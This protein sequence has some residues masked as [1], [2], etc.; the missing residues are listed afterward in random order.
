LLLNGTARVGGNGGEVLLDARRSI[1][2]LDGMVGID[3]Q[4]LGFRSGVDIGAEENEVPALGFFIGN[5]FLDRR[6]GIFRAGIFLSVRNDD[7]DD[8]MIFVRNTR[9]VGNLGNRVA[10][11]I[12]EGRR[13]ADAVILGRHVRQA[14]DVAAVRQ[15]VDF[16]VEQDR[17]D[18]G[19]DVEVFFLG[20]HGVVAADSIAFQAIHGA[21]LIEDQDQVE[22][23]DRR[24]QG[25]CFS[26]AGLVGHG[27]RVGRCG[28]TAAE[29]GAERENE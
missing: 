8:L 17:R 15:D 27:R 2:I 14:V 23:F 22:M 19:V 29:Q 24:R 1:A 20:N 16:I 18:L 12:E 3:T 13:A 26:L 9:R 28:D 21:A 7:E 25:L 4:V 10:Y 11:S 6:L 5:H